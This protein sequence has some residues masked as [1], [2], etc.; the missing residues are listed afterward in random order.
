MPQRRDEVVLLGV[1]ERLGGDERDVDVAAPRLVRV[2]G[3]RARRIRPDE[4]PAEDAAGPLDKSG[5]VGVGAVAVR[6]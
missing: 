2:E 3:D 5:E 6:H 4:V 1:V